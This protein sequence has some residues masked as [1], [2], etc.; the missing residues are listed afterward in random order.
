MKRECITIFFLLKF[1]LVIVLLCQC[2]PSVKRELVSG[3]V[4]VKTEGDQNL[5]LK[6]HMKDGGLYT[7]QSWFILDTTNILMGSGNYYSP[8]RKHTQFT[9]DTSIAINLEEVAL[10]ETNKITGL[11]GKI[12]GM[13]LIM[14]PTTIVTIICIIDPKACFGSCP[15]FYAWNGSKMQ[16]MAE[17]FSSSVSKDM[18]KNDADMLYHAVVTGK[19]FRLQ[20][21]NEALETHMVKQADIMVFPKIAGER[22]YA[23]QEM[24][25]YTTSAIAH[26]V[27]CIAPEGD[28]LD[29]MLEMD[30]VERTSLAEQHDLTRKETVEVTFK[31]TPGTKTGLIIGSRQ[32]FMTT[33]LYYQAMAHAGSRLPEYIAKLKSGSRSMKGNMTKL[34]ELLGGIEI[35]VRDDNGKWMKTGLIDEMGP[36]A[37]D[38]HLVPLPVSGSD[39]VTIRIRMTKGLWRI[40]QL[41]LAYIGEE[42]LPEKVSPMLVLK[43][44]IVDDY[45]RQL[46]L[47]STK[48]LVTF[49]GDKYELVYQLPGPGP[50]YE[51]F[52]YTRGY[53]LEWMREGWIEEEDPFKVAVMFAF[54]HRYLK[55]MAPDFKKI[56]P[57]MEEAFWGSRY[58]KN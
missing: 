5:Y 33:Y 50:D 21:T 3:S 44:S 51:L 16:L 18:E 12:A 28:C 35:L 13:S 32:T 10:F 38:L 9:K 53:Y 39:E 56:E 24:K 41:A 17:G 22:V 6:A 40:D 15:T 30:Q 1:A 7:L 52:L 47:D 48:Y 27:S 46:L 26:P 34:W 23:T 2:T 31:N 25:Y 45:A 4:P 11:G 42:V 55:M 8:D 29:K 19:E 49:P 43:D 20:M 37:A 36:I 58:V 54:P 57:F 14:V